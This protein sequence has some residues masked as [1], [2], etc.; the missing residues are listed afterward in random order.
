MIDSPALQLYLD[1]HARSLDD[2][3]DTV[4]R[5]THLKVLQAH[6]LSGK[7]QAQFLKMMA[8]TVQATTI[9]EIGTFTGYTALAFAEAVGDHGQVITIECDEEIAEIAK[10]NI[11]ASRHVSKIELVIGQA[12]LLLPDIMKMRQP[13]LVFIDADK[14]SNLLYYNICIN[15]MSKGGVI[16]VDNVL[17]KGKVLDNEAADKKTMAIKKFNDY[18][19]TD[20]RVDA[21]ILPIRDGIYYIRKK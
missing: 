7:H 19:S 13:Q 17:W 12:N 10:G 11:A 15:I 8:L 5:N 16:L 14:E 6:M 21:C 20:G 9:V 1:Q 18:V 4:E 2:Y 3:L